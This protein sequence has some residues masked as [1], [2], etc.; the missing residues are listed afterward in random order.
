MARITIVMANYNNAQYIDDSIQSVQ[1]QNFKDWELLIVDDASTDHS[2][3]HIENYLIDTRIRILVM[4]KNLGYTRALI[5]GI[6]E[7]KSEIIGILDSDDALT[8]N[9]LEIIND[10]YVRAPGLEV[11]L[12]QAVLCNAFLEPLHYTQT[13]ARHLHE[14]LLWMRGSTA[15]R[16]F[17]KAAYLRTAG[18]NPRLV[19]GE[20]SDLLFKLEEVAS[21]L[22]MDEHVYLYRQLPRSQSKDAAKYTETYRSIAIAVYHAYSRRLGTMEP[23]PP[24]AVAVAWLIAAVR[25]SLELGQPMKALGF[26]IRALGVAPHTASSYRAISDIYHWAK[27][28][29]YH[30]RNVLTR[31]FLPVREFQS[32]TGDVEPDRILCVPLVHRP[33]HCVYG[34]D[35][36]LLTQGRYRATFELQVRGYGYADGPVA[37]LD[38]YENAQRQAVLGQL[39][40]VLSRTCNDHVSVG[41]DFQ[42]A[43]GDRV[44][45]RVFWFGQYM[46]SVTGILI[47]PLAP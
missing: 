12:T 30:Q 27:A 4:R 46:L 2:V 41:V 10:A 32:N 34:G 45:F 20:D 28:W 14:P 33:G 18:I 36:F 26:A 16:T 42:A 6:A 47:E 19:G 7:A 11:V 13:A 40:L 25:Y 37:V 38:V 17:T 8:P 31:K 43:E 15:F 44:E 5:R 3:A 22:R 24:R 39:D 1:Q 35:Y 21:V 29:R 9:A 23:N